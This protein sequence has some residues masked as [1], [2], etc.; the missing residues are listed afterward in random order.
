MGEQE[1]PKETSLSG[2]PRE[3]GGGVEGEGGLESV[4]DNGELGSDTVSSLPPSSLS[5]N[6]GGV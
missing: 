2:V 6:K 1:G 5:E 3:V 4:G